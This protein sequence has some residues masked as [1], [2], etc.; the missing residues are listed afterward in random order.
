[1][2]VAF[3]LDCDHEVDLGPQPTVG[4]RVKCPNCEVELE[5]IN[6]SPP[7]LD[8]VYDGPSTGWALFDEGWGLSLPVTDR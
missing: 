6:V 4:Q 8:W 1:M 5:L 3:C 2:S 7:E